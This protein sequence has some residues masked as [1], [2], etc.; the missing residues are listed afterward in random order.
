MVAFNVVNR[1]YWALRIKL[2]LASK[3]P[4]RQERGA[5]PLALSRND[6]FEQVEN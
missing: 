2:E 3:L 5:R 1:A 4:L 6:A